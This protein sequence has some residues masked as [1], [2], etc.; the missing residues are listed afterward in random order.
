M[1]RKR[2]KHGS[3][4]HAPP[5]SAGGPVKSLKRA[6]KIVSNYHA[7]TAQIHAQRADSEAVALLER[8]LAANGGVRGYQLASA[9]STDAHSTSKWVAKTLRKLG[10]THPASS[11][12]PKPR[13]LEVGAVNTQLLECRSLDVRAID[14]H[15]LH[16]SRIEEVDFMAIRQPEVCYDVLVL[17]M[18]L[19]CVPDAPARAAMLRK[20]RR[21][22]R[23]GGLLFMV[24]PLSC[25]Q[26]SHTIDEKLFVECCAAVG[27]KAK[28]D[29]HRT[30]PKLWFSVLEAAAPDEAAADRY[31]QRRK[32]PAGSGK[33]RKHKSRG[34]G[35][36]VLL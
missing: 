1:G 5:H 20:L 10:W 3:G 7:L 19:N 15:S 4:G 18:V 23:P 16:P 31:R 8:E 9:L 17:S 25:L 21:V 2:R 33:K 11:K 34:A 26:H 32:Q 24:L 14:L 28:P 6:R 27:L 30:T 22:L 36:D 12:K 35:F 13:V 29:E